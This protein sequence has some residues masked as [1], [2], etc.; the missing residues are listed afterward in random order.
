MTAA[1]RQEL[2]QHGTPPAQTIFYYC[3]AAATA[4]HVQNMLAATATKNP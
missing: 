1:M 2:Q 4:A 3:S